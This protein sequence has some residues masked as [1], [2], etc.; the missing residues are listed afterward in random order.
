MGI[1]LVVIFQTVVIIFIVVK[2]TRSGRSILW[3][4][5]RVLCLS[6][7]K[8]NYYNKDEDNSSKN[9]D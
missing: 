2:E 7:I 8:K 4:S 1:I 9:H 6:V 5:S 3:P